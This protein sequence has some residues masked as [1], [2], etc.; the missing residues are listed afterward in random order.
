MAWMYPLHSCGHRGERYQA[1]GPSSYREQQLEAIE[2]HPCPECRVAAAEAAAKESGLPMLE[3]SPKQIAWAAE[4]RE[5]AL[6]L[7]PEADAN[8]VRGEKSAKWWIDHRGPLSRGEMPVRG[9]AR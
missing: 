2:S 9:V 3:G 8:R 5:R 6:R 7:L 4:I 1:Y